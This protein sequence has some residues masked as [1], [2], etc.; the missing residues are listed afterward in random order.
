MQAFSG[1]D[2]ISFVAGV[3]AAGVVPAVAGVLGFLRGPAGSCYLY[4]AAVGIPGVSA[5]FGDTAVFCDL[6]LLESLG[7]QTLFFLHVAG[8]FTIAGVP[9]VSPYCCLIPY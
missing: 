2:G 7:L 5:F 8:V 3:L 4:T 6:L 9:T 1:A